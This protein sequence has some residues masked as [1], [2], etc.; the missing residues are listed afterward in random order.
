MKSVFNW[1]LATSISVLLATC[2]CSSIHSKPVRGLIE[3]ES[4]KMNSAADMARQ[5]SDETA[6]RIEFLKEAEASLSEAMSLVRAA[7]QM[8]ALV[9]SANQNLASKEGADAQAAAYVIASAYLARQAG[10]EAKVREQFAQDYAALQAQAQR[11]E[12]SW[13]SLQS[14]HQQLQGYANQSG[15]GAVDGALIAALVEQTPRGGDYVE[16]V[17]ENSRKLNETLERA[18]G[19]IPLESSFV[20]QSQAYLTELLNLLERVQGGQ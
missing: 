1:T 8:H 19:A 14:L 7:E 18:M 9:F 12:Q 4:R 6:T 20:E 15:L 13:R 10:L 17:I 11:I 2:G 3:L 5:F 16:T